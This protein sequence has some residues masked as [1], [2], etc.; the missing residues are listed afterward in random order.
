LPPEADRDRSGVGPVGFDLDGTLVDT[1]TS[2]PHAYVDTMRSLAAPTSHGARSWPYGIRPTAVV[3]EHFLRRPVSPDDT[4]HFHRRVVVVAT[5][6]PNPAVVGMLE[7]LDRG[8]HRLGVFTTAS[9]PA[10]ITMLAPPVSLD[11]SWSSSEST[12]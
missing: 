6:Q 3:L 5:F 10:A 9:R 2:A 1:M 7:A 12:T 11:T 4:E 8:G